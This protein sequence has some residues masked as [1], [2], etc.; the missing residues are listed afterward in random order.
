MKQ[1][2]KR[3]ILDVRKAKTAADERNIIEREKSI[4]R[5]D[6]L[7]IK[8]PDKIKCINVSKIIL[9]DML[10]HDTSFAYFEC[11]KLANSSNFTEKRVGYLGI[12]CLLSKT[13]ELLLLCTCTITKDLCSKNPQVVSIALITAGTFSDPA[14]LMTLQS[15]IIK[16]F[17]HKENFIKFRAIGAALALIR[18]C[19]ETIP[20]VLNQ[21]NE[22]YMECCS[23]VFRSAIILMTEVLT[24]SIE[25][26][27]KLIF[28]VPLA[29]SF[30]HRIYL[31]KGTENHVI[32]PI[33]QVYLIKFL[34]FFPGGINGESERLLLEISKA[35]GLPTKSSIKYQIAEVFISSGN[36]NLNRIGKNIVQSFLSNPSSNLKYCGLRICNKIADIDPGKIHISI[37]LLSCLSDPNPIVRNMALELSSKLIDTTNIQE[38]LKS[39]LSSLM[40][41]DTSLHQILITKISD[42][43]SIF[44]VDP[45]WHLDTVIRVAIIP[46]EMIYRCINI[47]KDNQSIQEYS[48]R[49]LFYAA[50]NG[51]RQEPLLM[52]AFWAIGEYPE[53]LDGKELEHFLET[54]TCEKNSTN[55]IM[56]LSSMLFK[57]GLALSNM[58]EM[59]IYWLEHLS[60]SD[61]FE[62]QQRTCEYITILKDF[63]HYF[64]R[65]I[66][67]INSLIPI[68][69]TNNL[70][71]KK[72]IE[73]DLLINAD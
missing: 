15:G 26:R 20:D 60:F 9:M 50:N 42:A 63:T 38:V 40:S 19:P 14:I 73:A 47:I 29:C 4:I 41:T 18:A 48:S 46:E 65:K 43:L 35:I 6:I 59:T 57:I 31:H 10:G 53:A 25:Y 27:D 2:L 21:I 23:T 34:S 33:T 7:N 68:L 1:D 55:A 54:I 22:T 16:N 67:T 24:I 13:P 71:K 36:I 58:K 51:F 17:T 5:S 12:H 8:T 56:Y 72:E 61:D 32:D 3:L 62:L 45:I 64:D 39:Y 30:L 70:S 44:E 69:S 66:G 49:K 11:A 28:Y 52:L 37:D